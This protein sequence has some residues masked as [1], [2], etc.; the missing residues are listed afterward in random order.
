MSNKLR[1]IEEF[2]NYVKE[3]LEVEC[4]HVLDADSSNLLLLVEDEGERYVVKRYHSAA[5]FKLESHI[6]GQMSCL[7]IP[8]LVYAE[9]QEESEW[10]W[11]VYRYIDGI[12]LRT[13]GKSINPA[14]LCKAFT[15][16]G[17]FLSLFHRHFAMKHDKL[18]EDAKQDA[19]SRIDLNYAYATQSGESL[20]LQKTVCF[21]KQNLILLDMEDIYG[22]IIKDFTD[23][24]ILLSMSKG[25][26]ELAGVVDFE[27]VRYAHRYSDFSCL[28][29]SWLLKHRDLEQAFWK[30]YGKILSEQE[31][32][33]T[34]F[35]I[36]KDA[37]ELCGVLSGIHEENRIEGERV[38]EETLCWLEQ[39]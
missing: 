7:K 23:K 36:L 30:G 4:C 18:L 29:M 37:L 25:N 9:S 27:M 33:A 19:V 20:W 6:L 2:T 26:W 10:N 8:H 17:S 32:M 21:L 12:P 14:S 11:L 34:A 3:R 16:I 13:M 38:I 39:S 35:F 1:K 22:L 31:K 28:Y 5:A 15:E 24:H